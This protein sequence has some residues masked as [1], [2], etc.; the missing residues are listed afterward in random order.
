MLKSLGSNIGRE[1]L[2][3]WPILRNMPVNLQVLNMFEKAEA[4]YETL[5]GKKRIVSNDKT[6]IEK[7]LHVYA[8]HYHKQM[9]QCFVPNKL[10]KLGLSEPGKL[11]HFLCFSET[12][13]VYL[14]CS[15]VIF[16]A[17]KA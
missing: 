1:L 10:K 6:K 11:M 4:E 14:R 9:L 8:Q 12:H 2:L 17:E 3:L 15:K 16:C 7:V 5:T 13:H